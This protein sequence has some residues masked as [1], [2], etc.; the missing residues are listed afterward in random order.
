MKTIIC[1]PT[2]LKDDHNVVLS[3]WILTDYLERQG[4]EPY[5][6]EVADNEDIELEAYF[7]QLA[8]Y[9]LENCVT[10]TLLKKIVLSRHILH[11]YSTSDNY[12]PNI[13]ADFSHR[14]HFTFNKRSKL[15][16]LVWGSLNKTPY[17]KALD[18][19]TTY[20]EYKYYGQSH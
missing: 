13:P 20:A 7:D 1:Y 19:I 16:K 12:L 4:Y 11:G 9:C 3:S 6:C 2:A 10:P 5:Y 18:S 17:P 14:L 15:S 8:L